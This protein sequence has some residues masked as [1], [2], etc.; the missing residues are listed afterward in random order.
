MSKVVSKTSKKKF[1]VDW[2]KVLLIGF[3]IYFVVLFTNQQL[4]IN[5]YN[6]KLDYV[7]N[8][9]K[10]AEKKTDEIKAK[11]EKTNDSDYIESVAREELG[12]VKPYEKIFIDVNK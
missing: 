1:K 10:D 8:K 2:I 9:I 6:V 5:E 4:Q 11:Q 12:L 3:V 7:E